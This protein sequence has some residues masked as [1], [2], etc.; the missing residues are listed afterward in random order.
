LRDRTGT[1]DG[2]QFIIHGDD[3]AACHLVFHRRRIGVLAVE[4][5]RPDLRSGLGVEQLGIDNPGAY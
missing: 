3:D 2:H 4:P 1:R 5:L